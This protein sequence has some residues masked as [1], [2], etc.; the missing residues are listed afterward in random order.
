M[1]IIIRRNVSQKDTRIK[2][3]GHHS[4][5][6]LFT[7]ISLK[8]AEFIIDLRCIINIT[9]VRLRNSYGGGSRWQ[10]WWKIWNKTLI[11]GGTATLRPRFC[12]L[13]DETVTNSR[14][15]AFAPEKVKGGKIGLESNPDLENKMDCGSITLVQSLKNCFTRE[16]SRKEVCP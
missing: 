4:F 9:E 14:G 11:Q 12:L 16:S 3:S 2:E 6:S 13:I 8:V 15:V 7:I 1:A 10:Q 5:G